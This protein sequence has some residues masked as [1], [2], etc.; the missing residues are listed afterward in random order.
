MYTVSTF[1]FL[2][3][4]F[5][6]FFLLSWSVNTGILSNR[7]AE[8]RGLGEQLSEA[9]NRISKLS[10]QMEVAL[11]RSHNSLELCTFVIL[12]FTHYYPSGNPPRKHYLPDHC[13]GALSLECRNISQHI[14]NFFQ[15]LKAFWFPSTCESLPTCT[16]YWVVTGCF[17][18]TLWAHPWVLLDAHS[19]TMPKWDLRLALNMS[20]FSLLWFVH[21]STACRMYGAS[22]LWHSGYSNS[23]FTTFFMS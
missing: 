15:D 16:F 5:I 10:Q 11:Q 17:M 12:C 9:R 21:I 3:M 8:A 20:T 1:S 18:M 2:N 6:L 13:Q 4:Y 19:L 7:S 14:P 23:L 22:L